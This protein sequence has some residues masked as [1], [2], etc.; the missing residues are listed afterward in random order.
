MAKGFH[1]GPYEIVAPL[2]AGGMGEVYRARDARLGRDVAIKILAADALRDPRFRVRFE[3]EARAIASMNDPRICALYDIGELRADSGG[4]TLQF[5]VMEYLEGETL[6]ERLKRGPLRLDDILRYGLEIAGA[7]E[8]AHR[9]QVLH[10]DLKPSNIMMTRGGARLFDFGVATFLPPS[11][12]DPESSSEATTPT[13]ITSEGAV[14]GTLEYMAPEQLQ[15]KEADA[16]TD[17]FAFGVCLYQMI[18]GRRPFQG[19]SRAAIVAAIL[20]RDPPSVSQ[21]RTDLPPRLEWLVTHCLAKDR[22][23]RLQTA[24]DVALELA[25]IGEESRSPANGIPSTRRRWPYVAIAVIVGFVGVMTALLV[26]ALRT[27][28]TEKRSVIRRFSISLPANA[29]VAM[30]T[31]EKLAVSPDGS[32]IAYVGGRDPTNLYLYYLDTLETKLVPQTEGARGPFFSPDGQSIGFSTSARE[33]KKVDVQKGVATLLSTNRDLRGAS[34]GPND[35]IVFAEPRSP[36]RSLAV[37]DGR[38]E[39]LTSYKLNSEIRWPSFMP[40]GESVLFTLSDFSGDYEN[41]KLVTSAL[42]DG[43][44][45]TVLTGATCGRY[46]PTGHLVYFHSE[47]L[48][49]VRFDDSHLRTAGSPVPLVTDVDS[50]FASGL[51]DFAVSADGSLFYLPRNPTQSQA[52][53]VWVDRNGNATPVTAMRRAFETPKISPDG[54]R[55][56][57]RIG[58]PPRSDIWVYEMTRDTWT[59][60]TTQATNLA[61]VWSPDGRQ[62]AFSSN[63]NGGFDLYVMP[64]DGTAPPLQITSRRS[65]DFPTSWSRDGKAIAVTE[66]YRTSFADIFTVAPDGKSAP[67]EFLATPSNEHDAVFSPDGKWIAFESNESGRPEIYVQQYTRNGRRWLVSTDGGSV[68][69]WRLDGKELFYRSGNKMMVVKTE[70]DPAFLVGKP[71]LLFRGD[72]GQSYDITADGTRFLMVRL[73]KAAPR[74]EIKVVLGLFNKQ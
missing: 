39:N 11:D 62:I 8:K 67:A 36:L 19:S 41:A 52:E 35:T 53:L 42:K 29:P 2:G 57:V 3:R 12:P 68:P 20:E 55:V 25:R 48:F 30:G 59:R 64:S 33:L 18:T 34:W 71:Q 28:Q 74:T 27:T 69:M 72:F 56:L 58:I 26:K 6:E 24:H 16:R 14:V 10:R 5:I 1:L 66:Q 40:G 37:P 32:R 54:T 9:H 46:V 61:A 49:S 22:D 51:A 31:F 43:T 73:P 65:W 70:F 23:D 60:L 13:A 47:S 17:V 21:Y 45:K 15:G 7:L 50:S 44:T 63:R 38:V 4:E